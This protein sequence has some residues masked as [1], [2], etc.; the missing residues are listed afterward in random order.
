MKS[1]KK[2]VQESLLAE[3][4][5]DLLRVLPDTLLEVSADGEVLACLPARN[6][7]PPFD[8]AQRVGGNLRDF[9]P[10]QV[11][12]AALSAVRL[13]LDD[14]LARPLDFQL[15]GRAGASRI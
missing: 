10:P 6:A 5:R 1:K 7:Q 9:L 15:P 11:C 8:E 3:H 12:S 4:H 14:K 2:T 13:V